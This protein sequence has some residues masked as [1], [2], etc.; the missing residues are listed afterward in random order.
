MAISHYQ[1]K[2]DLNKQVE[3]ILK[4]MQSAETSST[5]QLYY[6]LF[7]LKNKPK[8]VCIREALKYWQSEESD[9]IESPNQSDQIFAIHNVI[10]II[11]MI[12]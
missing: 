2:T 11:K 7:K 4:F 1:A 9:Q 3:Q 5:N 8:A 6:Y 10:I 12:M